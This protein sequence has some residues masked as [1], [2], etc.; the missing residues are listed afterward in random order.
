MEEAL[1]IYPGRALINS[2]SLESEK[3]EKML[4]IAKKY[5]AMFVLLPLS[6]EGLPKDIDDKKRI[7]ETVYDRAM[8]M[9]MAHE[10]I[11]VDGLVATIGA[12]PEA[13]KE[14]YDTIAYCKD[15]RLLPIASDHLRSV[16]YFVRT[17]GAYVCQ[18][19]ISYYGNLQGPYYGN[20]QS[21]TGTAD[22]CCVCIGH[23]SQPTG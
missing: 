19:G 9:G 6:D 11:V 7:I 1:R 13:A 2:I 12:N 16:Q 22:E 21:V 23:A 3:I 8:K 14:C 5:G 15:E 4:P 20:R 18:Y 10:D 17:A